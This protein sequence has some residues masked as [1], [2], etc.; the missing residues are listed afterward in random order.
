MLFSAQTEERWAGTI[1]FREIRCLKKPRGLSCPKQLQVR[2]DEHFD[3]ET[4]PSVLSEDFR[5]G[6]AYKLRYFM[7]WRDDSRTWRLSLATRNF[8]E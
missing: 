5:S 1:D 3:D 7:L 8:D 6:T 4:C 2:F